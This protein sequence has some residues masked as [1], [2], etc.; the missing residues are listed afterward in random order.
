MST[1]A[2]ASLPDYKAIFSATASAYLILDTDMTIVEV[3]DAYLAATGRTRKSVLGR[4]IFD[5]FPENPNDRQAV[6]VERLRES[7]PLPPP[8]ADFAIKTH[9]GR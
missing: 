2:A 8:T 7:L 3:N 5:A 1:R 9:A 6:G 4:H